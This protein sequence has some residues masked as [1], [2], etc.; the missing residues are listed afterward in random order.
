MSTS[1]LRPSGR[2]SPARSISLRACPAIRVPVTLGGADLI[3]LSGRGNRGPRRLR[4][5]GRP[6]GCA[7]GGSD[8]RAGGGRSWG[9]GAGGPWVRG[10]IRE[11]TLDGPAEQ[12]QAR[13]V[14]LVGPLADP[15]GVLE[16]LVQLERERL[17]REQDEVGRAVDT[18][19]VLLGAVGGRDQ[20]D[21]GRA[22]QR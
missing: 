19:Q 7:A 14:E 6:C 16:P 18:G 11:G 4:G 21:A 15:V 1:W 20:A 12:L 2:T 22:R 3:G 10:P 8:S 5:L 9:R 13:R 17:A